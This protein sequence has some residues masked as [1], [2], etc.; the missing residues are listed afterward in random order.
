MNIPILF[1]TLH[2]LIFIF[3]LVTFY[4]LFWIKPKYLSNLKIFRFNVYDHVWIIENNKPVEKMINEKIE[5]MNYFKN[6]ITRYYKLVHGTCGTHQ[7]DGLLVREKSV[8]KTREDVIKN[9]S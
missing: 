6:N 3:Y 9:I 1:M 7:G 2:I 4:Y 8:F 5:S